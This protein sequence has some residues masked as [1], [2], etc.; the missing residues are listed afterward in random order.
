MAGVI[1]AVGACSSGAPV[2][3]VKIDCCHG[4]LVEMSTVAT[5][6]RAQ[7]PSDDDGRVRLELRDP[8]LQHT[9]AC[10]DA[11]QSTAAVS[12]MLAGLVADRNDAARRVDRILALDDALGVRPV[13]RSDFIWSTG[14]IATPFPCEHAD[15]LK[16]RRGQIEAAAQGGENAVHWL[17]VEGAI[18]GGLCPD[19]LRTLYATVTEA[20]YPGAV[21]TVRPELER[22]SAVLL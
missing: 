17:E 19:R 7:C 5:K 6:L 16:F 11:R 18:V 8:H 1:G 13:P 12:D 4:S 15:D 9:F 3:K 2:A 10:R 20:G 21:A 22:A 14:L